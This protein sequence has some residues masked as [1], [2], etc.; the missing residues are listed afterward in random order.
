MSLFSRLRHS[1]ENSLLYFYDYYSLVDG[2][3]PILR[4]CIYWGFSL[5]ILFFLVYLVAYF[6]CCRRLSGKNWGVW[7]WFSLTHA[8]ARFYQSVLLTFGQLCVIVTLCFVAL[9]LLTAGVVYSNI[10]PEYSLAVQELFLEYQA[11]Q[12][13]VPSDTLS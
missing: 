6:F 5:V 7:G 8:R 9:G 4:A 3:V 1:V 2:G 11:Q 12:S 13:S 10:S